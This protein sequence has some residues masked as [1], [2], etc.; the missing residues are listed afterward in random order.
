MADQKISELVA[1][2]ATTAADLLTI[3]QVGTG[4]SIG[5]NKKI[6]VDDFLANLNSPVIVNSLNADQDTKISGMQD[7][8]LVYVKANNDRVGF[9]T[10][11]PAE[12][13]EINGNFAIDG[14]L[15]M[16]QP[17]QVIQGFGA[18]IINTATATTLVITESVTQLSLGD[19]VPGQLKTIIIKSHAGNA[20]LVPNSP[21]PNYQ[22]IVFTGAGQSATVQYIL[23]PGDDVLEGKWYIV[24]LVGATFT[25]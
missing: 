22:K 2:T 5:T 13:V 3:V 21:A 20:E 14:F 6:R 24:S 10:Q 18:Q 7:D 11:T 19:G 4:G 23:A 15:R 8:N 1:A 16:I 17:P 9:G 25:L 12:K